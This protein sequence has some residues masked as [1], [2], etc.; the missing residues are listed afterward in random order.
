ML[1]RRSYLFIDES[2]VAGVGSPQDWHG[3]YL[4][5]LGCAVRSEDYWRT[6][7]PA[8]A[9]LK[10][11]HFP[12]HD[13]SQ[14]VLHRADIVGK[15]GVF[16]VLKDARRREAFDADL[17]KLYDELPYALIGI[18]VDKIAH[19]R[20]PERFYSDP[21][22]WALAM[23]LERYGGLLGVSRRVGQVICEA[24]GPYPDRLLQRAY[25]QVLDKGTP[26]IRHPPEFFTAVLSSGHM[27]FMPKVPAV[28]GLEIADGLV[29][30]AKL[31]ILAENARCEPVEHPF[32]AA[33]E[34]VIGKKWN[35]RWGTGEVAGYGKAFFTL[36]Y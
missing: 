20:N 13:P 14:V 16:G 32:Q 36:P 23:M 9:A 2:G 11:R 28:A 1:R 8:M 15:R 7:A 5:L 25:E 35:R 29:R 6:V 31:E 17:L 19:A 18:V 12:E 22:H 24:R 33:I 30:T 4:G 34:G 21:Y 26:H 10:Q 3:Q 27:R